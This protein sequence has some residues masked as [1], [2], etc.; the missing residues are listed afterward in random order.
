MLAVADL[1]VLEYELRAPGNEEAAVVLRYEPIANRDG[2]FAWFVCERTTPAGAYLCGDATDPP[3]WY[4][5]WSGRAALEFPTPVDA[6][7]AWEQFSAWEKLNKG[8]QIA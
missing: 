7:A 5:D 6:L 3:G 2:P 1:K 8:E 4:W